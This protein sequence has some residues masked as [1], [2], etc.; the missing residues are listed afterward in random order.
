M[1]GYWISQDELAHLPTV[2]NFHGALQINKDLASYSWLVN[3]PF[4]QGLHSGALYLNDEI[5]EADDFKWSPFQALRRKKNGCIEIVSSM[6]MVFENR[7]VLI[8]INSQF[9]PLAPLI[10]TVNILYSFF[11]ILTFLSEP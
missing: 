5:Y 4:S 11:R 7:G 10:L 3:V 9:L 8:K 2:H 1:P 6:R